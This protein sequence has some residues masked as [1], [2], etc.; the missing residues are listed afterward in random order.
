MN[1]RQTS[2]FILSSTWA[3]AFSDSKSLELEVGSGRKRGSRARVLGFSRLRNMFH[4]KWVLNESYTRI[5]NYMCIF[6]VPLCLFG[7]SETCFFPLRKILSFRGK[8]VLIRFQ[9]RENLSKE[10]TWPPVDLTMLGHVSF[11]SAKLI[12]NIIRAILFV[13]V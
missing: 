6:D 2:L 1:D 8:V 10:E 11:P 5:H 3:L 12:I 7:V 4:L 13:I 9:G